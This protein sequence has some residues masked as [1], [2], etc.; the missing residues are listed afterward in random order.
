MMVRAC[1][2]SLVLVLL[3]TQQLH[4]V[5]DGGQRVAEFVTQHRQ[6]LVLAAV[7]VGQASVCSCIFRSR[8]L[9]SVMSRML[10]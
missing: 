10:H 5:E 9:R 4:G 2:W 8:R 7:Q 6:E 3:E 1:C